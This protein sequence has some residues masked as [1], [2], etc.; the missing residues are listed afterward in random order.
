MKNILNSFFSQVSG[1]E[2]QYGF[3]SKITAT[4]QTSYNFL[5]AVY[6]VFEGRIRKGLREL[7]ILSV[8][9]SEVK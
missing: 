5:D 4:T 2:R 3:S 9:E 8:D 1:E 6:D 7:P